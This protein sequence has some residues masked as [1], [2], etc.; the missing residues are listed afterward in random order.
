[1]QLKT[2]G[3]EEMPVGQ[4][5]MKSGGTTQIQASNNQNLH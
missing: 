3:A 5:H 4:T 1:M 2:I